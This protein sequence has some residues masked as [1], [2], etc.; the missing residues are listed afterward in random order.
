MDV[1]TSEFVRSLKKVLNLCDFT[2]DNL[3]KGLARIL[4]TEG[5]ILFRDLAERLEELSAEEKEII[6][7]LNR[8]GLIVLD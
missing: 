7:L 6:I 8:Q 3:E 4:Y 1:K 2:G 5:P